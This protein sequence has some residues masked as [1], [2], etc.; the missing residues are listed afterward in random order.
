VGCSRGD[1]SFSLR[2]VAAQPLQAPAVDDERF[3]LRARLLAVPGALLLAWLLSGTGAGAFVER[4]F[5]GMWLHELGH[6]SAAWLSGYGA[7]PL[8][9]VTYSSEERSALVTLLVLAGLGAGV[10]FGLR[11]GRAVVTALCSAGLLATLVCHLLPAGAAR[12]LGIFAGDAG[13]MLYGALLV[14]TFFAPRTS[15]L[16]R[17][18]V[19]WGLLALGAAAFADAT[20]TWWETRKDFAAMPFGLENGMPSD[21]SRL[22]DT[23]HWEERA[24]VSRYLA[25]AAAC[26]ALVLVA[27]LRGVGHQ[28][29]RLDSAA[30]QPRS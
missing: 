27:W 30:R 4:T 7:V 17:G 25:V 5:A 11:R 1:P 19:R 26:A 2:P 10:A 15:Q 9:W 6:A 14:C 23:W 18:A 22:V 12:Q 8:P 13:A 21:A 29:A 3:E 28:R 20:R 24:L 16:V